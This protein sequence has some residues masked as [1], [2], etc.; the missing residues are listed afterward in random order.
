MC[1]I[2]EILRVNF[3]VVV[4]YLFR[5]GIYESGRP[6]SYSFAPLLQ[7]LLSGKRKEKT[8]NGFIQRVEFRMVIAV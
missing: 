2:R 3:L 8:P 5:C 6:S 1:E 4:W 7:R